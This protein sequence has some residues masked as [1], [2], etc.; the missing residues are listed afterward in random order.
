MRSLAQVRITE[1]LADNESGMRDEDGDQEDWIE[2]TNTG[3]ASVDLTGWSLTD[4][5]TNPILWTFPSV[6]LGP[7]GTLV[8][9][10]SGKDR[11]APSA[12]LHT[13]F[14]LS[15][16]GEF[17]GLY[18]PGTGGSREW[19]DGFS[20]SY[21]AQA[22][23]VSYGVPWNQNLATLVASGDQ[24]RYR[25]LANSSTGQNQ[26]SG[27]N[28]G[29][30][31]VGTGLSGGWNVS[32]NF[33]DGEWTACTTGLGYDTGGGLNPWIGTN[34]QTAVRNVNPSVLFRKV[35][36]LP[37]PGAYTI[38]KLR[39]K[40]EDG[41]VA[42]INGTEV[43]RSNFNGNPAH[44]ST[45]AAALDESIVNSWAEFTIPASLLVSGN[46][47]LA[48]Q[49]LNSSV[50]SSD[51]LL[52]PE[53]TASTVG[54]WGT[55]GYFVAPTPGV[56]N[57]GGSNGPVI[58]A[59]TPADP[60]ISRP[61]GGSGSAPIL[62]TV[63]VIPNGSPVQSVRVFHRVM[64]GS[65][66]QAVMNDSGTS[67]D[68]IAG[69]GV[70]SA[71]LPTTGLSAGQMF[72]WRFEASDAANRL[73]QLPTYLDPLDSPRYFGTVAADP[74][75]STSSLP[76]LEWFVEG[77]PANGP[78]AAA[79]R[80]ACYHL[81]RFYDNIGHEIHGQSTAGFQKKSY[82][83]DS[84]ENHRFVWREGER[85]VKDLNLLSNYADKTKTRNTLA[86]EVIAMMGGVHH[87]CEPVRV[88]LNGAFH[89]VMDLME[90]GDDRML[91]RNGLDGDGALYKMYDS[92][93]STGSGEKKTRKEEDKSD[94]QA[95]ITGLNP[96][97][98]LATRRTYA[99][100][101]VDI[102]AC[103]DYLAARVIICD[104]DHG[105]KNYYVYRDTEG[106]GQ[107][108]MVVWDVDLSLGH[109]YNASAGYFED[110]IGTTNPIRHGMTTGN[111]LYQIIGESPEF[112][113]MYVR[114]LRSLFDRV[115]Q[116]PGTV[117]G[118]L[119]TRMRQIVA[120][121][122]PDPANPSPW[123]DGDLDAS[124]WGVWGRGLRPREEVEYVIANFFGPRRAFLFNQAPS[125]RPR[126]G[127]TEGSGDPV[128]D[129]GQTTL[130]GMVVVEALDFL[131]V[132]G[133]PGEEYL[134]LKNTTSQAVDLSGW[135]LSG[136]I[137]HVFP[138]GTVIP[139]GAGTAVAEYAGLLHVVKDVVSFRSRTAGPRGG[140]KRFIQ[141]NYDGDLS[142]RGGRVE[143]R[144]ETGL[145]VHAM[146]Y[147]GTPTDLQQA[148]RISE[149][150]YHPA[151]PDFDEFSQL[152]GVT[153][154]DF[155]YL[156]WVNIGNTPI[157]LGGARFVAGIDYQFPS[158]V[159]APGARVVLAKRPEA[160]ALRYPG[161]TVPVLGPYQG[162]LD[163][164][165]ERIALVDAV[166][167][168][169]LDFTY[170]DGWHPQ[171]DGSGRSMVVID[172]ATAAYD[173]YG[174]AVTWAGSAN[175]AGSPGQ[176]ELGY[177]L[178]YGGW[179]NRFFT[180]AEL[181][182]PGL[183]GHEADP[184]GDGR[185]NLEEYALGTN[186][187]LADQPQLTFEWRQDGSQLRPALV[188]LRPRGVMDV[189]YQLLAADSLQEWQA[190][191]DAM[192]QTQDQGNGVE[193]VG[194]LDAGNVSS[195]KRFF[196]LSYVWSP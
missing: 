34:C 129:L 69:D 7:G 181:A 10:A 114:R 166:G 125:T 144:D 60:F 21:P 187:R 64:W 145:L 108:R 126:F 111:R 76:V 48:V 141:G 146:D 175:P 107:W 103:I 168:M 152:P 137:D 36:S 52:L 91:E 182:D 140:E 51:F 32:T 106:T 151:D 27:S 84:N 118:I 74:S 4:K 75:Q 193:E 55:P 196:R 169:V 28:Y 88:H 83:F 16:N 66:T 3:T 31:A 1:F 94:L 101:H 191:E 195:D 53:V 58:H 50:G 149:M 2:I 190:V 159:L 23:D 19:V 122:D 158:Q 112:R 45:A 61:Q 70:Y 194:L 49:G 17:L 8:V 179:T 170:G 133:N 93:S 117:D 62:V 81:G 104:R 29:S 89:G 100:D 59:A 85:P 18:R 30:G 57:G 25:V 22:P 47:L 124:R 46:N 79:F 109:D 9:W 41:F 139:P 5:I 121:V 37:N 165:G 42:W 113:A 72:R 95:L 39:M 38:Y 178:V 154:G 24:A 128:P 192:I 40:Y 136:G 162:N 105:H 167:E 14:S 13:N 127:P 78:T 185:S 119:E 56:R 54:S 115:L 161:A 87:F 132:S 142:A 184:D 143:L 171:T 6:T 63:R 150:Q 172:P 160:F 147:S 183:H 186:P 90:D 130:P 157:Q 116:A 20:P 99:Y 65:E 135:S 80:G 71:L 12:P 188:F 110:A 98:A 102:P 77:S 134:V 131:P 82:D 189:E 92:L 174:S 180:P 68:A 96:S 26:Y 35:F 43:A 156:E 33:A 148:L 155:E 173:A 86:H 177:S 123:T 15:R 97:T 153:E 67:G 44:N 138:G 73:G 120:T 176:A 11:S 163:N 164:A